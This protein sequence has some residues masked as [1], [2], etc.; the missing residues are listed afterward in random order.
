[1]FYP[2]IETSQERSKR[3]VMINDKHKLILMIKNTHASK[4]ELTCN[5]KQK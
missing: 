1:M 4:R 2:H 5:R 3:I